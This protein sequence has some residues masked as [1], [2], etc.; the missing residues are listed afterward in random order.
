MLVDHHKI[1]KISVFQLYIFWLTTRRWIFLL[2]LLPRERDHWGLWGP[3]ESLVL[4]SQP[5]LNISSRGPQATICGRQKQSLAWRRQ[6]SSLEFSFFCFWN[7]ILL[8]GS[9]LPVLK[10]ERTNRMQREL[11]NGPDPFT[12]GI[13]L[14]CE[15]RENFE[16][17]VKVLQ[18]KS[19]DVKNIRN[20]SMRINL[21]K[22]NFN[23]HLRRKN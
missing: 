9:R 11:G 3:W 8:W 12:C 6:L 1:R 23:K 5:L 16:T 2:F 17:E 22:T 18:K 14:Y 13:F 4:V 21:W 7:S 15:V 19:M 20:D 10:M